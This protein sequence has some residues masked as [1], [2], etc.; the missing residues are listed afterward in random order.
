[1]IPSH[2]LLRL[3]WPEVALVIGALLILALDLG[4]LREAPLRTRFAAA[5]GLGV[6]A[7]ATALVL[8]V[9]THD[10]AL[11]DG[12]LLSFALARTVQAGIV[13]L[14]VVTLWIAGTSKFTPHVGEFTL[15]VLLATAAMMFLVG[16]QDL[17]VIFLSLETLSLSLY[18]LAAFDKAS[19]RAAQASLKYFLFGGMSAAFLLYGFSIL[20]GLASSTNLAVIGAALRSQPHNPLVFVAIV[21][22]I[23]G[24]AFKIAAVPLHFWVPEVYQEAPAPSAAFIA[25]G[26]KVA[27]FIAFF[28]ILCIGFAQARGSVGLS[29]FVSGWA[30]A[31]AAIALASMLLG[32]LVAIVQPRLRRLLA[33]SAIAHAGYMLLAMLAGTPQS[34]AAL[35]YYV[36]TYALATL[37]VFVVLQAVEEPIG[38][39]ALEN[40][41]GLSRRSPLLSA[42]LAV[43]LLSLAG[44][45]PLA[46]FFGKFYLFVSLLRSAPGSRSFLWLVIVAIAMSAVSLY[47]YLRVLKRVYVSD[48]VEDAPK[49]DVPIVLSIVAAILAA[50]VILLGCNPNWLLRWIP[51]IGF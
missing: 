40:F 22:V 1:M 33:Y 8:L 48:V 37:G 26:S 14:T 41:S 21:T 31:I 27:S 11:A 6:A 20:Y 5:A 49:L 2:E 35:V 17:L 42:C 29:H 19:A 23:I 12:M 43:F 34:L 46:G 4:L 28:Q 9:R 10:G 47:Y 44:I 25:S 24:F 13:L 15:L 50:A 38:G 7:C 3:A 30:P 39:D 51:G 18:I 32:N 36:F 16:T 45:P